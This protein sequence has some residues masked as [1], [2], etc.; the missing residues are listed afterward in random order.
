[1]KPFSVNSSLA[2]LSF[3]PCQNWPRH[4]MTYLRTRARLPTGKVVVEDVEGVRDLSN[5]AHIKKLCGGRWI[6]TTAT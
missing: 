3:P 5:K 1:M 2:D 6:S 4:K